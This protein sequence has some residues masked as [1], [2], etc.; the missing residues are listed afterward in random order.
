MAIRRLSPAERARRIIETRDELATL[1]EEGVITADAPLVGAIRSHHDLLL[2]G[3]ARD[4]DV[5]M[6]REE[7]RLSAGMRLATLVGAAALSTAWGY[8]VASVWDDL[9]TAP[10][11]LL[12]WVPTVLLAGLVPAAARRE[13]SG[14]IANIVACV[15]AISAT[16]AG[17]SSIDA[18]DLAEGRWPLFVAG[19]FSFALAYRY[20]LVLPLLVGIFT[21][22][23]WLWSLESWLRDMSASRSFQHVEPVMLVGVACLAIATTRLAEPRGFRFAWTLAGMIAVTL[24][25]LLLGLDAGNSWI[26]SGQAAERGWQLI[27]LVTYV[28]LVWWGLRR[29]DLFV[30]RYAAAMLMLFLF[31]R[32]VDWFWEDWPKWLF[33]LVIGALAFG[34]LQVMRRV[35]ARKRES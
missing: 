20:R 19:V 29:D 4:H 17:F 32:M 21:G 10:R 34:A 7:A 15:A 9:G 25:M 5:D 28:G 26:G 6:S 1:V 18:L 13:P 22:G 35:R 2:E 23:G 16:V 30:A 8:L 24:P 27:S 12:V 3:F 11:L 14:Y 33:F 31:L